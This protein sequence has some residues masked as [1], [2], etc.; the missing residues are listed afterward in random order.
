M[1]DRKSI[2]S[3]IQRLAEENGGRPPGQEAFA[4][5]TGVRE[6]EWKGV[7]WRRW[8]EALAEA[9]LTPNKFGGR[10][11][12]VLVLEQY[13]A[14]VGRLEAVPVHADLLLER[15]RNPAFPA[16]TVF[17]R[18][19][20]KKALLRRAAAFCEGRDDLAR[21]RELLLKELGAPLP[22]L[23]TRASA[24]VNGYVY[25]I[26]SGKSYKIGRTNASGR[27]E[28]ELAIQLPTKPH[29]V[30]VI[31]TDDPEGIEAYWH[32]RFAAKRQDG[33]WFLLSEDDVR[34]FKWRRYQ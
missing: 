31:Q 23:R 15:R 3:E 10:T 11:D 20:D 2:V 4:K 33:E 27:R 32:R 26:R 13:V 8:S 30:H 19:G 16:E 24:I 5:A 6:H 9:G 21:V 25:L 22:T 14:L 18:L 12:E 34:A 7:F 29:T 1:A 28:R 17:R